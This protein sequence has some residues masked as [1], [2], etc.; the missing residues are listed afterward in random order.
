MTNKDAV[1]YLD[2]VFE[3]AKREGRE[4]LLLEAIVRGLGLELA[5]HDTL[6]VELD[7]VGTEWTVQLL[8]AA[9]G[10]RT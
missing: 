3:H 5:H 6:G 8:C 9:T 7:S 2:A 1:Q 4:A 10:T